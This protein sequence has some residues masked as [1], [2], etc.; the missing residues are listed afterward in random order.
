MNKACGPRS[1]LMF[2]FYS[3]S[4]DEVKSLIKGLRRKDSTLSLRS[5]ASSF[6]PSLKTKIS[7]QQFCKNLYKAGV[8]GDIIRDRE[9]EA[10][11]IFKYPN[12]LP[13]VGQGVPQT[14]GLVYGEELIEERQKGKSRNHT[15]GINS[16]RPRQPPDI[17]LPHTRHIQEADDRSKVERHLGSHGQANRHQGRGL[18]QAGVYGRSGG[19][20]PL[21][22]HLPHLRGMAPS[23]L[24]IESH[25]AGAIN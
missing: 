7:M 9:A 19:L 16:T 18:G 15:L 25:G 17:L 6:A 21:S 5:V 12:A 14:T 11:A 4:M 20:F 3:T 23:L 24:Y 13:V 2:G 22:F 1:D 10:I 8:T